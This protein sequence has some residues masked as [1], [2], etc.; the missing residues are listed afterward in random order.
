MNKRFLLPLLVLSTFSTVSNLNVLDA[1]NNASWVRV[2]EGT[3]SVYTQGDQTEARSLMETFAQL[4]H[5]LPLVAAF[6]VD[7]TAKLKIVVFPS[8]QQFNQYRLN[9]GSCAFYQKTRNSDYVVLGDLLPEHRDLEAHEFTHF[10]IA[11]SGLT[12]PLW[13]NEGLADFYST[14]KISSDHVTFGR[15]VAGRLHILRTDA[16]LPLQALFDVSATSSYY[17]EPQRMA[18]FYSES[19]ALTHML[20]VSPSYGPGFSQFLKSLNAGHSAAE[21]LQMTY[22]KTLPQVQSDLRDYLDTQHLPVIQAHLPAPYSAPASTSLE[23]ISSAQMDINLAELAVANP[24]TRAALEM[25]LVS[26]SSTQ[27]ENAAAE[28][29]L[30]YLA[31]RQGKNDAARAHFRLAVD[32]HST[33]PN[34]FFYLAHLDHAAGAPAAEIV[35]LLQ[36]ALALKPDLTEARLEL[37]LVSTEDGNFEQALAALK[38]LTGVRPENAYTAAYT[39]AYCLSQTEQFKDARTAADYAKTLAQNDRDRAEITDLLSYIDGQTQQ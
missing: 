5:A 6:P 30:G 17:S 34:V 4:R 9:P 26:D 16:W 29:T 39:K 10:V 1:E 15:P 38:N 12:I 2:T 14:F 23:T 36:Q 25:R 27:P 32:R 22:N 7:Q 24:N 35:P 13:L 28:E 3:M 37:A 31:L 19:W 8:E 20:V 21:S 33:D 18:L 11:H